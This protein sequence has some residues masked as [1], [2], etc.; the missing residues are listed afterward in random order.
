M[1]RKN[2][3]LN[4]KKKLKKHIDI[5]GSLVKDQILNETEDVKRIRIQSIKDKQSEKVNSAH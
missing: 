2:E 5:N 4:R 1:S 3:I